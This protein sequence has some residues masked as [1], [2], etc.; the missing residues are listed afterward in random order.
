[1]QETSRRPAAN[2]GKLTGAALLAGVAL[3]MTGCGPQ[4]VLTYE[5]AE[6]RQRHTDRPILVFYKNHEDPASGQMKENLQNG[7]LAPLINGTIFCV[8]VSDFPPNRKFVAQYG[9]E[10]PPALIVIHPDG[11]YHSREGL[12]SVEEIRTFLAS[13]SGPGQP[14]NLNAQVPRDIDYHWE[15]DYERAVLHAQQRNRELFVVYKSWASPESTELL[16]RLMNRPEVALHFVET[17]NCILDDS[18]AANRSYMARFGI[19]RVPAMVLV[20]RDGTYHSHVGPATPEE[21]VR[22]VTASQARR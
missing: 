3:L 16:A 1:M 8:L 14:A 5:E 6:A 11:T 4:T 15:N 21:I 9:V 2:A 7:Q 12:L 20:H 13:A 17:V 10:Y 18:F 22:F 19:E